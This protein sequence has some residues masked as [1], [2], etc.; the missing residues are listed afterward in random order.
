M[1]PTPPRLAWVCGPTTSPS[2]YQHRDHVV[3]WEQQFWANPTGIGGIY[4]AQVDTTL[5]F[6]PAASRTD[7]VH[8][9][10]APHRDPRTW[11][12]TWHGTRT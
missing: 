12:T 6:V 7:S 9:R 3:E 2:R 5:A 10:G 1:N 4:E 8:D 11:R